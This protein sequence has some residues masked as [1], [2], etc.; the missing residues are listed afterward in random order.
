MRRASWMGRSRRLRRTTPPALAPIFLALSF[1]LPAPAD[2]AG[3]LP[4][5][6]QFVAGAG[7]IASNGT[8]LTINQTSSRG[9]IDWTSFSIGSG[10]RV[11]FKNGTGATLNRVTG[12]DPSSILGTLTATGSV[13][14]INP[15]GIVVGPGG[16]ITTGG[17]F[18]ATTLDTDNSAFMAGGPL[19]LSGNSNASVVNLGKIGSSGGDV[20]L[21]A[22]S[23]VDNRGSIGAP[24]GT[25]ELAVGQTVLLQDASGGRQ[26]FVQTG[27]GGTVLNRGAI[28]AAQ[29]S[30]QAAD[31]NVYALAGNHEVLRATGTATRDGHIWLVADSGT[32]KLANPIRATN[33]DGSGGT[34]DTV[35]GTLEFSRC[36]PVVLAGIW[37]ITTP[38]FTVDTPAAIAFARSLNAGTSVNLQTTGA[39]GQS[40]D[41]VVASNLRWTRGASLTLGAYRTLTVDKGVTIGNQ[42]SGNLT[43]RADATAIDNGGSVINNGTVDWSK[44]TGIVSA[45]Y[46]MNGRYTPGTL[47]GNAAWSAPLYSGLVTQLTAYKLINSLDD[48][49]NLAGPD[50][51]KFAANY[52]LGK[53]IDAGGGYAGIDTHLN[54]GAFAFTG[55]FDGMDHTISNVWLPEGF[56]STIGKTGVVRNLGITNASASGSFDFGPIG[57]LAQDNQGLVA[58]VFTSGGVV[59]IGGGPG[60]FDAPP[61]GGLVGTNEGTI[62]RAGSSAAVANDGAAGGLVGQNAGVIVQS[63]ASGNV[64]GDN[65]TEPGGLVGENSGSISQSYATGSV[66]GL[67]FYS[68]G[69]VANNSGVITESFATGSVTGMIVDPNYPPQLGGIAG[70]NSGTI[71]SNVYW[72]VATTGQS[73]GGPGVSAA[74]GLTAAQMSSPASFSGWSFAPGGVWAMP[75]G[76]TNPVLAWQVSGH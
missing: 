56:F 5:G 41:I 74:N 14:L 45:L 71:G 22:R 4:G 9:V 49:N 16:V 37:N 66:S 6:G 25:A 47:I 52:A 33:A 59:G 29:I 63:F 35:A 28:E 68:G 15:Q 60:I 72:N 30:L 7:S 46:D 38:G 39:N 27:S 73:Q 24:N 1:G 23:A 58:N 67:T 18:V 75:A 64:S 12:G 43:L 10:N 31:G 42:G 40:G 62:E 54:G 13:Y 61:T 65:I 19:T 20:F 36:A 44:S 50:P 34:V 55:Q 11:T 17:R 70:A 51:S 8:S 57:L 3:P 2:A 48:I 53:D 21:I 26:V 32:V 76:A 69:L